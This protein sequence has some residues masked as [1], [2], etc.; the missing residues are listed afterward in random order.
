MRWRIRNQKDFAAG[1]IYILAGAGFSLGALEYRM[2]D[3]AR[4]G[5]GFFPF[6]IGIL[7]AA[8]GMATVATAFKADAIPERIK[9][10]ELGTMAWILGAVILFGLLLQPMGLVFSLVVL[11]L[12]SSMASHEFSWKGA[13]ANTVFLILF[14]T[15]VFIKGISLQMPL[16]PSF[17]NI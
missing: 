1:I 14:S 15:G 3:P 2:G 16:W 9:K 7:L 8:V 12:V 6:W 4:M 5:P 17:L 11:I 13:L 10:P